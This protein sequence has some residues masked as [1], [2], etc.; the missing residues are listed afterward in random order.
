VKGKINERETES[1]RIAFEFVKRAN[2]QRKADQELA[3][4]AF[5][6]APVFPSA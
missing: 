3:Q 4:M 1:Q 2:Q 5:T 6:A